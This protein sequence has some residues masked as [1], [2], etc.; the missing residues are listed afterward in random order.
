MIITLYGPDTYRSLQKLQ[1]LKKQFSKKH[2][3]EN[4]ASFD[5][6]ENFNQ[7]LS[8]L[9][10]FLNA[11]SIFTQTQMAICHYLCTAKV[12]KQ[13]EKNISELIKENSK[14]KDF[15]LIIWEP[16]K[17]NKNKLTK[18]STKLSN[19]KIK[20]FAQPK[21][22]ELINLGLKQCQKNKV[23]CDK[24]ILSKLAEKTNNDSG[25]FFNNL[26]ILINKT[27][28]NSKVAMPDLQQLEIMPAEE[29][30]FDILD[31]IGERKRPNIYLNLKKHFQLHRED[32]LKLLGLVVSHLRKLLIIKDLLNQKQNEQ[33]IIKVTKYNPY[34][35][36]K[37]IQQCRN[38]N[39]QDL[40]NI[41]KK[42]QNID[43]KAK[44]GQIE[45][46]EILDLMPLVF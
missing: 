9:N 30:I 11:P 25:L 1:E 15:W 39:L 36:K 3:P 28:E 41:F 8:K 34:F 44:T 4:I 29:K 6:I 45:K 35:A 42:I 37:I 19:I 14:N 13:K 16:E 22:Y 32:P 5:F 12:A 38:Y 20:E 33:N 27:G 26:E 40:K 2:G 7:E 23:Q 18:L 43:L 46:E 31:A 10:N 21:P 17:P 24:S